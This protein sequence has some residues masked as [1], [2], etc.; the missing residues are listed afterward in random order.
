MTLVDPADSLAAA[1]ALCMG[2]GREQSPL[3]VIEHAPVEFAD[4]V[5]AAEIKYPVE[6]DLYTPL[7][8]AS[9]LIKKGDSND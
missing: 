7:L 2:E 9:G 6:N 1:A 5:N 8:K 4:I 3:C